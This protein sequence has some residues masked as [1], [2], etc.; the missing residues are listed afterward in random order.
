MRKTFKDFFQNER[1]ATSVEYA[2]IM[3]VVGIGIIVSLQSVERPLDEIVTGVAGH[4]EAYA[5]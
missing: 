3:V 4:M 2:L 1:G 5:D